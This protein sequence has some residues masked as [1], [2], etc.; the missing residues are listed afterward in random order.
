MAKKN[1]IQIVIEAIDKSGPGLKKAGKRLDAF[2]KSALNVSKKMAIAGAAI[3][4]ALGAIVKKAAATGDALDKLSIRTGVT[5]ADLSRLKLVAELAGSSLAGI[6]TGFKRLAVTQKDAQDKL[7]ESVRVFDDLNVEFEDADG[8]LR[9]LLDVFLDISDAVVG[10]GNATEA[11]AL[12]QKAL[13]RGGVD[14]LPLLLQ[15]RD[16]IMATMEQSDLLGL[17]WDRLATDSAR[18]VTDA[19]TI[20]KFSLASVSREILVSLGPGLISMASIISE[21]VIP[22]VREFIVENDKLVV[23]LGAVGLGLTGGAGI[24]AGLGLTALAFNQ[25]LQAVKALRIGLNLLAASAGFKALLAFLAAGGAAAIG[26]AGL[27]AISIGSEIQ[28]RKGLEKRQEDQRRKDA[29]AAIGGRGGRPGDPFQAEGVRGLEKLIG[30]SREGEAPFERLAVLMGFIRKETHGARVN[31]RAM[32]SNLKGLPRPGFRGLG[33]PPETPDRNIS[34]AEEA[35]AFDQFIQE[36]ID[37]TDEELAPALRGVFEGIPELASRAFEGATQPVLTWVDMV[38]G[39]VDAIAQG[40]GTVVAGVFERLVTG[41]GA[42]ASVQREMDEL[43]LRLQ[44]AQGP[45]EEDA[46]KKRIEEVRREMARLRLESIQTGNV[47]KDL[48]SVFVS[49][50]TDIIRQITAAVIK[51]LAFKLILTLLGFGSAAG[52]LSILDILGIKPDEGRTGMMIPGLQSGALVRGGIPGVDSVLARLA[53]GEAVLPERL[54]NRILNGPEGEGSLNGGMVVIN[55]GIFMG[56]QA[57]AAEAAR[58]ISRAQDFNV[59]G[60]D[61]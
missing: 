29:R 38:L 39:S 14:L 28:S 55:A 30:L 15:G 34:L 46:L 16:A 59:T 58:L 31:V 36:M 23:G 13:G 60:V 1:V 21:R 57:E 61:L 37:S 11:A 8:N 17:T 40:V 49:V 12:A 43:Q 56:T 35:E 10:M 32:L 50:F 47:L 51:L 6:A 3:T 48:G 19:F 9:P 33:G 27:A 53:P 52:S 4:A 44:L 20:V 54:V 24:V 45:E 25:V 2:G 26:V 42:F 5:A 7:A 18:D 41:S 22:K